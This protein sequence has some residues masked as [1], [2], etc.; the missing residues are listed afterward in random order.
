[1]NIKK[2]NG[3][4][5]YQTWCVNLWLT[6]EPNSQNWLYELSNNSKHD[7]Y[8]KAKTLKEYVLN[9]MYITY[10]VSSMFTDMLTDSLNQVNWIEII[11]VNKE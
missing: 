1:M 4:T 3:Y 2:Y 6:N 8:D 11:E 7:D 5:N 9:N 10:N